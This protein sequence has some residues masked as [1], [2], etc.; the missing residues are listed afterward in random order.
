MRTAQYGDTITFHV[1][2]IPVSVVVSVVGTV[3]QADSSGISSMVSNFATSQGITDVVTAAGE[4]PVTVSSSDPI[5]ATGKYILFSMVVTDLSDNTKPPVIYPNFYRVNVSGATFLSSV[6]VMAVFDHPDDLLDFSHYT[7]DQTPPA[8]FGHVYLIP[9]YPS[10][11]AATVGASTNTDK[12]FG[13]FL[14]VSWLYGVDQRLVVSA[15]TSI[16]DLKT[17]PTLAVSFAG[18]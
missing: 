17:H 5:L 3:V 9:G 10:A 14:G 15:G 12:D 2:N 18:F 6:G 16:W 7:M 13:V 1:V 4:D 8:I 11:L